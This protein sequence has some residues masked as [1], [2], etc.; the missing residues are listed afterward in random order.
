MDYDFIV[1]SFF[2]EIHP[3]KMN[4]LFDG[5]CQFKIR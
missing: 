5:N 4:F 2:D 3:K 1:L